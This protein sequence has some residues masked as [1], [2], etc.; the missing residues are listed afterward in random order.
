[1]RE[2]INKGDKLHINVARLKSGSQIFEVVI[3]PDIAMNFKEGGGDVREALKYEKIFSDAKKGLEAK[4]EEIQK[5]FGTT[6]VDEVATKIIKEGEVQV[7][8]EYRDAKRAQKKQNIINIIHRNAV[9]PKTH[10]P[11][12]V[13][14]IENA[15]EE[16]K[17]KIDEHKAAEEQVDEIIKKLRIILPIKFEVKEIAI[18]L[19]AEEATRSYGILKGF[20]NLLREEWQNDG[21]LIAIV[22]IPGGLEE[23]LQDKLNNAT[24][25]NNEFKVVNTR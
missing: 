4:E 13:T 21:S 15:L 18:K 20:G 11:H 17:V 9:D 23:E 1:M 7:S 22:E 3:D 6:T 19:P 16:A 25:G 2:G 24:H 12:P 5:I 8:Q 10:I 14:R